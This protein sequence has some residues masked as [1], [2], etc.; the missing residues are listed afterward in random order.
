MQPTAHTSL[1]TQLLTHPA[2]TPY[3]A[4]SPSHCRQEHLYTPRHGHA[5]VYMQQPVRP[6]HGPASGAACMPATL[7]LQP[8]EARAS[9]HTLQTGVHRQPTGLVCCKVAQPAL[10]ESLPGAC[11]EQH[12]L[13]QALQGRDTHVRHV[14]GTLPTWQQHVTGT[15]YGCSKCSAAAPS[16]H[17]ASPLSPNHH[18][19]HTPCSC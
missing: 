6:R 17:A 12:W 18:A 15:T 4:H 3:P 8:V 19:H 16:L 9:Q 10:A 5:P 11:R 13:H 14:G 2:H 7:L 1:N